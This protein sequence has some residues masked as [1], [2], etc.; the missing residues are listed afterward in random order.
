MHDSSII[1]SPEWLS[2]NLLMDNL[3]LVD[4]GKIGI[5]QQAHLPKAVHL[6]YNALL[7]NKPPIANL[8]PEKE[9]IEAIIQSLGIEKNSFVVAYDDEGGGRASRFLWTLALAGHS[10]MALLDGGI[11]A[12]LELDLPYETEPYQREKSQYRVEHLDSTVI[13]DGDELLGRYQSDELIVWDTRSAGEFTGCTVTA[14]RCGHIPGAVNYSW[15]LSFDY[16]NNNRLRDSE[17]LKQELE[18]LGIQAEKEVIV[19]CQT[20]HRSSF[21]WVLAR[22]LGYKNV[23]AYAGSWAEWG[24][25]DDTPVQQ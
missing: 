17:I 12:W 14:K 6:N 24:N 19:H 9:T 22:H 1:V 4:V 25:R 7:L 3:L 8:P 23:R 10:K 20:H 16:S 11:H 21:A 2:E 5:Y 15:D 13:I 18:S